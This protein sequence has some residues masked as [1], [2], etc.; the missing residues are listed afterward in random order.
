MALQKKK[1]LVQKK[2]EEK[3]IFVSFQFAYNLNAKTQYFDISFIFE[4]KKNLF[5]LYYLKLFQVLQ[6]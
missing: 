1:L 5:Q 3:R 4:E 2:V 6:P